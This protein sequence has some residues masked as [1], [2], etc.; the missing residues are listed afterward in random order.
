MNYLFSSI[1]LIFNVQFTYT[2]EDFSSLHFT[3]CTF[4]RD[5][6]NSFSADHDSWTPKMVDHGVTKIS[7]PP[8]L[9]SALQVSKGVGRRGSEKERR[10]EEKDACCENPSLFISLAVGVCK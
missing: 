9:Y 8:P 3:E 4:N 6:Q 5:S 1:S 7:L 10:R 2:V